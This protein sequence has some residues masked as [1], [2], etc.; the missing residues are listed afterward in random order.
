MNVI[1]QWPLYA[2]VEIGSTGVQ[3]FILVSVITT[4]LDSYVVE[5]VHKDTQADQVIKY[6]V[7]QECKKKI[8]VDINIQMFKVGCITSVSFIMLPA[9]FQDLTHEISNL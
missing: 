8:F 5:H 9:H 2:Q 3:V 6:L 1:L 4:I 7:L